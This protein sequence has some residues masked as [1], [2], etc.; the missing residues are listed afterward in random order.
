MF[1]KVFFIYFVYSLFL[2]AAFPSFFFRL[3]CHTHLIFVLL[4]FSS[5]QFLS[6]SSFPFISPARQNSSFL[7]CVSG[8]FPSSCYFVIFTLLRLVIP[9]LSFR[10][11]FF[12]SLNPTFILVLH[13]FYCSSFI[14]IDVSLLSPPSSSS[15]FQYIYSFICILFRFVVPHRRFAVFESFYHTFIFLFH[16]SK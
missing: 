5:F 1:K 3:F 2:L 14:S 10:I 13:S 7:Y 15:H 16:S 4:I 6:Y 11:V 8:S 9:T 12:R